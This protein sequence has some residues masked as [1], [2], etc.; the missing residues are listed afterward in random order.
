MDVVRLLTSELKEAT[1]TLEDI[2]EEKNSLKKL[3]FSLRKY[4]K[5]VQKEQGEVKKNKHAAEALAANL[6]SAKIQKLQLETE[7]ARREAEEMK[8]KAQELKQEAE[9]ARAMVEEVEKKL[10]LVL[11][12]AKD[13]KTAKQ[14]VVKEINILSEVGRVPNSKFNGMIKMSNEDFEAMKTKAKECEDLVEKKEAIVMAELQQ[15]YA[16]K[17][18]VDRKRQANS[19][20]N[21]L[22]GEDVRRVG[23]T[24]PF[25]FEIPEV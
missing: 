15:I 14:R 3:M 25:L 7:G 12:E 11:V 1:K 24:N 4:L 9:R 19:E 17:I 22:V 16:R 20:V 23:Y 2:A 8:R 21:D 18:E 13:A 10:E 6:I 5:Q